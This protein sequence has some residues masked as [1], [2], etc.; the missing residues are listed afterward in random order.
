MVE[1]R[2]QKS[3]FWFFFAAIAVLVIAYVYLAGR[4]PEQ[5]AHPE[6]ITDFE[7]AQAIA[8]QQDKHLFLYFTGSDWCPWCIRLDR[9]VLSDAEF[10]LPAQREFVFVLL[11]FPRDKSG[12]SQALQQQ[13]AELAARYRI[14]GYPTVVLADSNGDSYAR[15]GYRPG[16]GAAY[17]EHVRQLQAKKQPADNGPQA[18]DD[19]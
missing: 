14:E 3:P 9:E 12:Q 17:L 13:N 15:T 8:A 7:Q 10:V 16:G 6:W 18:A 4:G 11:D 5:V 19:L 1:A 2:K